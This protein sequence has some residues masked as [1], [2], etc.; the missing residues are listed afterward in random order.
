[1]APAQFPLRDVPLILPRSPPL[2]RGALPLRIRMPLLPLRVPREPN[3][4]GCRRNAGEC[5]FLA[6]VRRPDEPESVQNRVAALRVHDRQ[7]APREL[8]R[9]VRDTWRAIRLAERYRPRGIPQA[10]WARLAR[11]HSNAACRSR[12]DYRGHPLVEKRTWRAAN[13]GLRSVRADGDRDPRLRYR[14]PRGAGPNVRGV[15]RVHDPR[16]GRH[17][18]L[19]HDLDLAGGRCQCAEDS[20]EW[21]CNWE[22][23]S[24]EPMRSTRVA[25]LPVHPP[26][27]H[28]GLRGFRDLRGSR[29]AR[30]RH[31]VR[32]R[33]RAHRRGL[34]RGAVR[35]MRG[36]LRGRRAGRGFLRVR[37]LYLRQPGAPQL[38]PV[39]ALHRGHDRDRS[40]RDSRRHR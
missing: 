8:A 27:S 18:G 32:R 2:P 21:D 23:N 4:A 22:Q 39:P 3:A 14:F 31:A 36:S 20:F 5:R 37:L 26:H 6:A 9:G 40:L 30:L 1:M 28:P 7:E 15:R 12:R 38:A 35:P 19:R 33:G 11:D 13:C 34:P 10:R 17:R 24:E 16:P 25:A 29:D